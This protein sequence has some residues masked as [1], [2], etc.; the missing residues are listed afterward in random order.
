MTN[1]RR[2]FVL[3]YLGQADRRK[4]DDTTE[5]HGATED[6]EPSIRRDRIEQL[7]EETWIRRRIGRKPDRKI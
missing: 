7:S 6:Q 1:N 2:L 3:A 4:S 5:S